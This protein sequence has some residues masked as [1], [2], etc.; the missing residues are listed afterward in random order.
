[1]HS[2]YTKAPGKGHSNAQ[3]NQRAS[4]YQSIQ[5][6]IFPGGKDFYFQIEA[7]DLDC[8]ICLIKVLYKIIMRTLVWFTPL[9][10]KHAVWRISFPR[11]ALM[12]WER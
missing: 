11:T 7:Q 5:P 12:V 3:L 1:M 8:C 2:V 4:H 9:G 6:G 10:R